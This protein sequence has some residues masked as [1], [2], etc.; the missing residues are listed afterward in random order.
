MLY[1]FQLLPHSFY[2]MIYLGHCSYR[3]IAHQLLCI[4]PETGAVIFPTRP[5]T[6]IAFHFIVLLHFVYSKPTSGDFKMYKSY[7]MNSLGAF[8]TI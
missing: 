8:I 2:P 3:Y 4:F 1:T 5:T 7:D 6:M